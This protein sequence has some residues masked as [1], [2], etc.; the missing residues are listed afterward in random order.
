MKKWERGREKEEGRQ[1]NKD[2]TTLDAR[3][4]SIN[5]NTLNNLVAYRNR[6][7]GIFYLHPYCSAEGRRQTQ[8]VVSICSFIIYCLFF[9]VE[10]KSVQW[11]DNIFFLLQFC[12]IS[13]LYVVK[14]V[15]ALNFIR[16]YFKCD[17]YIAFFHEVNFAD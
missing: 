11:L 4:T 2:D 8:Q 3:I 14:N 10:S 5:Y 17:I 12:F 13:L 15:L 6:L 9:Y 7:T 16:T 1:H